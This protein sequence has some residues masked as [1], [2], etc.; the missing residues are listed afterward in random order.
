MPELLCAGE[1]VEGERTEALN[2][3]RM[4]ESTL[5]RELIG[6]SLSTR[7]LTIIMLKSG[8]CQKLHWK[9]HRPLCRSNRQTEASFKTNVIDPHGLQLVEVESHYKQWLLVGK[10]FFS[11]PKCS[12]KA[13]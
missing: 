6:H 11:N 7:K 8:E 2:M 5:L 3:Q 4:Q 13:S 12:H 1:G 9:A 10:I